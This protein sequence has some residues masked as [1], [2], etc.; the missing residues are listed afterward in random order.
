[1]VQ[2]GVA[3]DDAVIAL[4][5][6]AFTKGGMHENHFTPLVGLL[7][8]PLTL[9]QPGKIEKQYGQAHDI[10]RKPDRRS[11]PWRSRPDVIAPKPGHHELSFEKS[12]SYHIL[13]APWTIPMRLCRHH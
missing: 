13:M 6:M 3:I 9:Q 10:K 7:N 11:V 2:K 4:P 1:T 12:K 5:L 8:I